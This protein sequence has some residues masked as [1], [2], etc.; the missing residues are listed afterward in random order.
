MLVIPPFRASS[1]KPHVS[2]FVAYSK[3]LRPDNRVLVMPFPPPQRPPINR[4]KRALLNVTLECL[5][6]YAAGGALISKS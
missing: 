6:K 3:G 1:T 4:P 2:L 5:L